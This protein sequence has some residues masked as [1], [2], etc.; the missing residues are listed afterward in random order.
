MYHLYDSE[1]VDSETEQ[2]EKERR[3]RRSALHTKLESVVHCL[4]FS[5]STS[6]H[7]LNSYTE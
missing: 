3:E 6:G 1:G 2:E 5:N 7:I 4:K